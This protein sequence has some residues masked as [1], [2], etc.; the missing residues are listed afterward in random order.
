[1]LREYQTTLEKNINTMGTAA[2]AMVTGMGVVF[3]PA[4]Y[5]VSLPAAATA[6]GVYLVNKERVATGIYAGFSD[7]SDYADIYVNI[8]EGEMVKLIP[9]FAGER[10]GTDQFTGTLAAGDAIEVGTDGKW[11]KAAGESRFVCGG[12]ANDAL[13]HELVIIQ[14]L[15]EAI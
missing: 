13:A 11:V 4:D 1:M 8:D 15:P 6:K 3:D 5:T 10:Y 14:V 7:L 12:T 2:T 9:L